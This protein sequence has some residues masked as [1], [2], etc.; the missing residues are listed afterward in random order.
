MSYTRSFMGKEGF[1]WWLGVVENRMDPLFLNRVQARIFGWHTDDKVLIPTSDLPW[2]TPSFGPNVPNISGTPKEG[3]WIFGFFT[4]GDSG[5]M[6]MYLGVI[7]AVPGIRPPQSKGFSDPRQVSDLGD[8]PAKP[9]S[10]LINSTYG[11]RVNT[12]P[13]TQY[14]RTDIKYLKT[15]PTIY[16]HYISRLARNEDVA[17]TAVEFRKKNWVLADSVMGAQWKEPQPAY[18][19][20]YPYNS[21]NES[22]SGHTVEVD[23]TPGNERVAI[24][25]RSGT[26]Q[27]MYPSGTQVEK[28][29]KDNYTIV[30]G[31]DFAYVQGKLELS[32]ENVANI[33]IKGKTTIEVDGDVDWK[34]SGGMN[35]SIGK[36]LN[37]KTGGNVN[38]DTG[39][40]Y[41]ITAASV[42]ALDGPQIQL[43]SGVASPA[44]IPSPT[45]TYKNPTPV[46]PVTETVRP[47]VFPFIPLSAAEAANTTLS[48]AG[49][50][51]VTDVPASSNV[52]PTAPITGDLFTTE[53]MQ[54][55]GVKSA[56]ISTYLPALNKFGQ[57]YGMTSIQSR[58]AFVAECSVESGNFSTIKENLNYTSAARLVQ[59]FPKYFPT[60]SAAQPYVNNPQGLANIVYAGRMGNGNT[61][62]GDGWTYAGKGLIQLTGKANYVGFAN[63]LHMSLTDAAAY[64]QTTDGAVESAF[65]FWMS[66]KLST[67]ADAGN[68]SAVSSK[69][70]G[71]KPAHADS[72]RTSYYNAVLPVTPAV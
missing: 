2:A 54:A 35:L 13:K 21:V 56:N 19:A 69:I 72:Q 7:P 44:G 1:I 59:I 9:I 36:D 4:D 26:T 16:E 39:A 48:S 32:V 61:A 3:D 45:N 57:K 55:A 40:T 18:G 5:Q 46:V 24:T 65:W 28:I 25:H 60:T 15:N 53:M 71:A 11:V 64:L 8:A 12:V 29:I 27:E 14:P 10:R 51:D 22:E 42:I 20:M 67:L 50:A 17:N 68:I 52:A 47:V 23:D 49:T 38:F 58:A 34:I 6:P 33:R 37:I 43:N 70:N 41:F 31:S 66:K 62:S 30:H 63:S